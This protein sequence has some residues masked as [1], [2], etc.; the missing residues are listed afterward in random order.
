METVGEGDETWRAVSMVFTEDSIYYGTD[1][2]YRANQIYRIDRKTGERE[3]LGEING[4]VFYSKR[5]GENLYF[6]T[7]AENAP[8]QTENVA[9]IWCLRSTG[10]R[11]ELS[12]ESAMARL[13]RR[14][15]IR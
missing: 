3:S 4:T 8:A 11:E 9:S 7:T 13:T 1:A 14:P 2:E 15:A 12:L 10:E 6:T 5:I